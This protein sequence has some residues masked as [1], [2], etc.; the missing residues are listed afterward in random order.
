MVG[1]EIH[2][3]DP[4]HLVESGLLGGGQCGIVNGDY[5]FVSASP[6][7][8]VTAY[9]DYYE[10]SPPG[11]ANWN[12]LDMR[13]LQA[14]ALNKPIIAGEVGIEAGTGAGCISLQARNAVLTA[15]QQALIAAGGSGSLV[16][17]WTPDT[18]ASCSYDVGPS[19]PAMQPGGAIG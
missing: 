17:D 16:W 12:A 14:T 1:G 5:Q 3:L 11:S 15:K 2:A 4:N 10:S 7:I 19:D 9:H 13:I 8:D 18:A 6:G